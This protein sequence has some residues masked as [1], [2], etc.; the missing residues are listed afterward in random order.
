MGIGIHNLSATDEAEPVTNLAAAVRRTA[1][2]IL[3]T[4]VQG[5]DLVR[6]TSRLVRYLFVCATYNA[7]ICSEVDVREHRKKASAD[8]EKRVVPKIPKYS[9]H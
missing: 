9:G 8:E 6:H 3:G 1:A 4:T 2:G 5:A 7:S